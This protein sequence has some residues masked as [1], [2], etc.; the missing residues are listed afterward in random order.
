MESEARHD[1][2]KKKIWNR[3]WIKHTND[4]NMNV[5]ELGEVETTGWKMI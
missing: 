2:R 3:I 1:E 5:V 4:G